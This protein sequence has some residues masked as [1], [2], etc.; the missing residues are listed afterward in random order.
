M[1]WTRI[2]DV[3]RVAAASDEQERGERKQ[4]KSENWWKVRSFTAL[5]VMSRN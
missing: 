1:A 3:D 5:E 4:M 2:S